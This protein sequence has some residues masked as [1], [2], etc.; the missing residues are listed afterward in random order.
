LKHKRLAVFYLLLT[1]TFFSTQNNFAAIQTTNAAVRKADTFWRTELY[2]GR[3]KNDGT[4]VSDEEWA[5]FVDEV[6]TP[7]FPDGL[8]VLDG[9]GQYR[10]ENGTIV[11]E[12]SKVMILLYTPKTKLVNSSKIDQI[13]NEYKKRFKQESVMR[14][15]FLQMIRVSF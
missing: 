10:L 8:T 15:D 14:I 2:F 3:D 13:R 9:N 7:K 12:K 4:Q 1:I 5:Q 11:K 6:V